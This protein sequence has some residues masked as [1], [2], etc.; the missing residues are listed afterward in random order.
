[1]TSNRL[2]HPVTRIGLLVLPLLSLTLLLLVPTA[3]LQQQEPILYVNG[4]DQSCGGHSPCYSTIQAAVDAAQAGDTI[5]IQAGNHG[6][7]VNISGKN[8]V[9]T[10]TEAD[11]II[12][13][14]DPSA[15]VG[16][17]ILTGAV[18]QCTNGY[19]IRLQ[20]S[21]YVTIR[22]L[23][24]RSAGGQA[25]SLMGG[26]NANSAIHIERNRIFA[27]GSSDCNGGITIARGNPGTL[28]LNNLIYANGRNGITFID[29]DGGPHYLINN[30]IHSNAWSGVNVARGHE[31]HLVNNLIM[32]NGTAS[33]STGGRF[34]VKREDSTSPQ[35]A[36]IQL[37]NNLICGNRLGEI[38]GP[39][40]DSTDANNLTPTGSEGPGVSASPGCEVSANLFANLNGPDTQPNTADDDF[41][42]T[43]TSPAI[44]QG[45]DPRTLGL[46]SAFNPL[47]EADF[48]GEARRPQDGNSSGI[49]E[50]DIGALEV[51]AAQPVITGIN[52]TSGVHGQ[53]VSLTVT[54]ERLGGATALTFLKDGAPDATLT[55]TGLQA[56]PEGTQLTASVAIAP[57]AAL[58]SRIVTVTTS[59]GTSDATPTLGNTFT[60]LG[61]LT[62]VP[63][64][65][66]LRVGR[67]GTL[68]VTLSAPAPAGGLTITLE[69]AASGIAGVT[70]P[71][72]LPAGATSGPV[73]V[74]G[75]AEGTTNVLASAPGFANSLA[76]VTVTTLPPDPVTVAPALNQTTASPLGP[77]TEFLYTGPDPIQTGVTPGAIQATRAA[78]IRGRVLTRD[79]APLSGVTVS[80]LSHPEYGTTLSRT[81]GLFDLAVN[82][83][84]QLVVRFDKAGYVPVQRPIT[85][86]WQDYAGLPDVV[87]VPFDTQVT[88]IDLGA[89]TPIQVARGSSVTDADGT[90]RATVLFRQGTT[91]TLHLPDGSTQPLTT[92]SVRATE[93]TVGPNG[94]QSMP[95]PL[96][97]TSAYTYAVELSADEALTAGAKSITFN[98]S[99]IHYV[100]NFLNFPVGGVVPVGSY[101]REQA[102]WIPADNGRVIKL[103]SVT[104]GLA[105]LD[106][107][108]SGTPATPS[109]L[110]A[111]GITD[112]ERQQLAALYAPGQS[113][114]R[115]PVLHFSAWDFNWPSVPP[116]DATT[117]GQTGAKAPTPTDQSQCRRGSV[118]DCENQ[119]LRES[120]PVVGTPFRL[121]YNSDRVPGRK[122]G[123]LD[124]P[125]SGPTVPASLQ[126]IV[127]EFHVGG[128]ILTATLPAQPNQTYPFTWDGQ[129]PYGRALAG[130]YPLTIRIGYVYLATFATPATVGRAFGQS[131]FATLPGIRGR[132]EITLWQEQRTRVG[133]G[134]DARAQGIGAWTLD[135]HHAYDP[136]SQAVLL[137]TGHRSSSRDVGQVI[138]TLT[139]GAF[140][141]LTVDGQGNVLFTSGHQIKK[142]APD[143]TVTLVA[144]TGVQ[145]Y[146]G[147]GGPAVN[148]RLN[149][150]YGMDVDGQG[151]LYFAD[152]GNYRIRRVSPAGIITT[153]AGNGSYGFSGDG[154]PAVSAMLSVPWGVTADGQGT[155]FIADT[156]NSRVRKVTPDGIIRTIAGTGTQF[157]C[158][159]G[160]P[161]T[162]ACV[163][164]P[165]KVAVDPQG[166]VFIPDYL[167]HRI[168]KVTPDGII[169]TVAGVGPFGNGAGGYGGDGGPATGAQLNG[170]LALAL[171]A[172]GNL[173]IPDYF[174]HRVRKLTPD[175]IITTMAGN[176]TA[177][178]SGDG[179]PATGAQLNFPRAA[180]VDGAGKLYIADGNN[181]RIRRLT[182]AFPAFTDQAL[183]LPSR[184][185]TELYGFD[186]VGR[187]LRTV[188]ALTGAVRTTF[189]YDPEGRLTSVTD[190]DGNVTPIERNGA[191]SPTA[192]VAPDG[193]RTTLTVDANGFLAAITNPAG[194]A[195]GLVSTADGLLTALTDPKQQSHTFTY[196]ARG[197]LTRDEDPAQGITV[198]ARTD[199]AASFTVTRTT[200]L[201]RVETFQVED[202]ADGGTRRVTTDPSGLLTQRLRTPAG[203]E[204]VTA[205][206][207]TLT[208]LT[209]RADPR[210]GLQAPLPGT[211]SV[212]TP[213]G[214]TATLTTTRALTLSDPNNV[215][216]FAT[217][218]DTVTLN[219]RTG[220]STYTAATKTLTDT[221]PAGRQVTSTLD[222]Q[223]RVLTTQVTGLA[224]ITFAYDPRG[225]LSTLT[226]GTGGTAR[227]STFT[228]NPQGFL[229]S[230]TDPLSR[231]LSFGY[232]A[233][234]RVTTQTLPDGRVI[235]T[236][237]DANGNVASIT[238]PSRPAHS[239]GYTP[240]D[241]ETSY[242][243]PDLGIGNVATTYTYNADRRLTQVIRP[244]GQSVTLDYE[245]TGGRLTTLMT[246]RGPTSFTY[247]PTTGQLS[248]ISAPGGVTLG[249]TYDGRLFTGST[250]TGPMAR[251]VSRTFD[252]DFRVATESV[253]GANTIAF[254][255]DGDSLLTQAGD[256][257]LTRN[258]QNG[259]LT[260]TT[261]GPV[262]DARTYSTFGELG[263][264]QATHSG[265]PLIN[266]QYT[267]D[268]L[269]RITQKGETIGS[270]TTTTVY[271][272][273]TVGR[274]KDVTV[275]GTLVA[276]YEYDANGNRLAITR[277]GTGTVSGI[278]DAQDRLLTY[279]AL[280]Y[281]YS[282]NGDVQS[283]TSGAGTTSYTYDVLG[284]LT[285]VT[286]PSGT[287]I[288]YVIDGQNRRIGKQVNGVLVQGFLY[289]D[290]L[291]PVAELDG[292]G[293]IVS[294]FIH[295]TKVNVPD[296]MIKGGITYRLL[297]D[298]LGS[299]RLVVDTATGTVAQR[300]DYDE[301]GQITQDTNPG[302]QPFS[303]AGGLYDQ[304]TK[305]TRFGAR[306]YDAF[307]GRWTTKDPLRFG[308]GGPNLYGYLLDD[309]VNGIDPWGLAWTDWHE[310]KA[311][312][313]GTTADGLQAV[314]SYGF[315]TDSD[316]FVALPDERLKGRQVEIEYDG[317]RVGPW[318]GGHTRSGKSLN[319]PYWEGNRRPQ[320][321]CGTD[322]RGRRT[323]RAGI[324]ISP[325][326]AK[327]LGIRG[328]ATVRWR[329][330]P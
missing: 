15:A 279:G 292:T 70:S 290:Q 326:L 91:A 47:L 108:G 220:T 206:D 24:I 254:Q 77:S 269:G 239:F 56:N 297:T 63:D 23:S 240:V 93:Y 248:G 183:T 278:Y 216:S 3:S 158:G 184:D 148:A 101:D 163:G 321:E 29:V 164:W 55:A 273:D 187:H 117:P 94:P 168:R 312:V 4:A 295:G 16:S 6:E 131:S 48:S 202:L 263:T 75:V 14:A 64:F 50:F 307:T 217:I 175:G 241:L 161:A 96:P 113:L 154:G 130:E 330:L 2:R 285:S 80:I 167:N 308:G 43:P 267:R 317:K 229:A 324:D 259:L 283:T 221:S 201:Q 325:T 166:N 249:Y 318:N 8:N 46:G 18:A 137:G 10:A 300:I 141:G 120:V 310:V 258:T 185:G 60:V 138:N 289:G 19:A 243:P 247:H 226:Q 147:D 139:A 261:V 211:L 17:V 122:G 173:Y 112:A 134:W 271:G 53:A 57:T 127:L 302:F 38:D 282:A 118:I 116:T 195:T 199:T 179:G 284:N 309:P 262:S 84:S 1:M 123:V 36:G 200:A 277:P 68:T 59:G 322:L 124:V 79:G 145:G 143:G 218:T 41:T 66:T 5:R 237:Y 37:Q 176:G 86:P 276:H 275:D 133:A 90:R 155:L 245:P 189:G 180:A 92:L 109:A 265:S 238:P 266:T 20:Q 54:G 223:G 256:L 40:L 296:Y 32:G 191:G 76:V 257:T 88:A 97:P 78:V 230:L 208:T 314:T 178:F 323:N 26:N 82:G 260:G 196:D 311:T 12:I 274:L 49:P 61:Q 106:I 165:A 228:Y 71:L 301:F 73:T 251:S 204:T 42:L 98:Q 209:E 67:Q 225:R 298:H 22:G 100:E 270:L 140:W 313:E 44:D 174:N 190:G 232:D 203:I 110:A 319:D 268:A 288:E 198:L 328:S 87:L 291:R 30:T 115:V 85:P 9:A 272:Y 169:R 246:S 105:D 69:S 28:I 192:I 39:A 172:A 250:W 62:L 306:D 151:N 107:S 103:L 194:E 35:P 303:F 128:R 89:P 320:A 27:N 212:R 304:H 144:G 121:H 125:V 227:T 152:Y 236:S 327:Q 253:N 299:V 234:G 222:P 160:A 170:P 21:K 255:Y 207:G 153:V 252:T 58:G 287:Q 186:A 280:T 33:G 150:P 142:R 213:S 83:G 11:R 129:D 219:G 149:S 171:D 197:H 286:L 162:S 329:G 119:I 111:L 316:P 52:P 157:Y 95:A 159:D 114:W 264:Y 193:Q 294:R 51:A 177:G 99:T 231:T 102:A 65:V 181:G 135:S 74:T 210:F 104:G 13:E 34:G 214:L 7:Q 81:D 242:T 293:T 315:K 136:G 235:Q 224:P 233:A 188:H 215:F 182:P 45:M 281:T 244:D 205:P 72:N 132:V 146:S 126:R 31:V 156:D 305:L 25:I